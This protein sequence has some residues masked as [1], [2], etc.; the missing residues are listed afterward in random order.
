MSLPVGPLKWKVRRRS[1]PPPLAGGGCGCMILA[2]RLCWGLGGRIFGQRPRPVPPGPRAGHRMPLAV[3]RPPAGI[4]TRWYTSG[5]L[6]A[7]CQCR[8][9]WQ[10]EAQCCAK[11]PVRVAQ[12]PS[13]RPSESRSRS[14]RAARGDVLAAGRLPGGCPAAAAGAASARSAGRTCICSPPPA[15]S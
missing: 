3:P 7:C 13:R 10:L 6:E 15:P 9:H 12:P 5:V 1:C 2:Q 11:L 8:G 14:P 4:E